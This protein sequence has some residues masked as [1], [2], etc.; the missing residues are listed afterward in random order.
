MCASGA[1]CCP[2]ACTQLRAAA[3][4]QAGIASPPSPD[5]APPRLRRLAGQYRR[6]VVYGRGKMTYADG[7]YY[8]GEFLATTPTSRYRHGVA[9]PM[10]DGKRHGYGCGRRAAGGWWARS[11]VGDGWRAAGARLRARVV[12]R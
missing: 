5:P 12:R 3:V 10:P 8:E 6:G 4:A 9:M 7:G 2:F 11:V 1:V